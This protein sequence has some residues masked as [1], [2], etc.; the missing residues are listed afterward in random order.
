MRRI[1]GRASRVHVG[2]RESSYGLVLRWTFSK[3]IN[4]S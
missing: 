1:D 4:V 2:K 3:V